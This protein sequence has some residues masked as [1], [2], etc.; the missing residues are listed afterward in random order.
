M[1][2][3]KHRKPPTTPDLIKARNS[4]DGEEQRDAHTYCHD[5][6]C[7]AHRDD[8]NWGFRIYRTTYPPACPDSDLA[9]AIQVLH[10]YIRYSCFEDLVYSPFGTGTGTGIKTYDAYGNLTDVSSDSP[11][12]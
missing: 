10:E 2:T 9:R 8:Y 1:P 5:F 12:Q 7:Y 6:S 11:E 3:K 4:P